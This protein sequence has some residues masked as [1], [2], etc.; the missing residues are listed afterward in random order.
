MKK[1][2]FRSDEAMKHETLKG[3]LPHFRETISTDCAL[4]SQTLTQQLYW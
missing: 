3:Y 4:V 2:I 1:D